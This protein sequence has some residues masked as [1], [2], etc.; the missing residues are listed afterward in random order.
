MFVN[1]RPSQLCTI[2]SYPSLLRCIFKFLFVTSF[3]FIFHVVT[4]TIL[5]IGKLLFQII[6]FFYY[7]SYFAQAYVVI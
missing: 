7:L 5:A 6:K 4:F 2:V 3:A 1:K